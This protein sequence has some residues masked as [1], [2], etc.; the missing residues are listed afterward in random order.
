MRLKNTP[1][2][3]SQTAPTQYSTAPTP[4]A[5][6]TATTPSVIASVAT[7]VQTRPGRRRWRRLALL[8][9]FLT[10]L[11]LL[12]SQ[13]PRLLAR[14]QQQAF[15]R[16][17]E[18]RE[19]LLVPP[20]WDAVTSSFSPDGKTLAVVVSKPYPKSYAGLMLPAYVSFWDWKARKELGTRV[21]LISWATPLVWSNKGKELI[22]PGA[23]ARRVEVATG[24]VMPL[25]S[26]VTFATDG[27]LMIHNR[28]E[29]AVSK[30]V[31]GDR[32]ARR[33][34]TSFTVADVGTGKA[35]GRLKLPPS[36]LADEGLVSTQRWSF[37]P[38]HRHLAL[39]M[40][41]FG[42]RTTSSST[43][44]VY[45]ERGREAPLWTAEIEDSAPVA[46]NA[47]G[48]RLYSIV[49]DLTTTR[50]SRGMTSGYNGPHL[51]CFDAKTGQQVWKARA[52]EALS[53]WSS[54]LLVTG[55]NVLVT[56]SSGIR[57][58]DPKTKLWGAPLPLT[59]YG[60]HGYSAPRVALSPDGTT[61]A[62]RYE[63]GIRLR[64]LVGGD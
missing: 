47:D 9:C 22:L 15:L 61:I 31:Q 53:V 64:A 7:P 5:S 25:A 55:D 32:V 36:F 19:S 54:E 57:L 49:R 34:F 58:Y 30:W 41:N 60:S 45:W 1:T 12:G 18:A 38:D 27:T 43:S 26:D 29:E 10:P 28:P 11:A 4:T 62:E 39:A 17:P 63:F 33:M 21:P 23:K 51:V 50:D 59:A 13:V 35:L 48:T 6:T 2:P 52:D 44:L 56:T 3:R 24:K 42:N 8:A 20:G 16:S 14:Q 46:F 40:L 37:S